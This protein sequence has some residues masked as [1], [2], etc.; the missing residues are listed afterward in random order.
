VPRAFPAVQ[1]SPRP[2]TGLDK[3]ASWTLM[4]PVD[5]ARLVGSIPASSKL[6]DGGTFAERG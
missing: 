5:S 3:P 4:V 6:A 1:V 2:G